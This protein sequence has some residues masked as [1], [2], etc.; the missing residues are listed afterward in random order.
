[1]AKNKLSLEIDSI[2]DAMQQV[3]LDC[4]EQKKKIIS[5]IKEIKRTHPLKQSDNSL[6]DESSDNEESNA[7][8]GA[9]IGDDKNKSNNKLSLATLNIAGNLVSTNLRLLNDV[10]DKKIKLCQIH[11]RMIMAKQAA[12][13]KDSGEEGNKYSGLNAHDIKKLRELAIN[14]AKK[15][16]DEDYDLNMDK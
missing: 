10:I 7:K 8:G 16:I 2:F 11:S 13:N 14:S 3:F 12:D 5:E 1:M 9:Q 15:E 6:D 4:D